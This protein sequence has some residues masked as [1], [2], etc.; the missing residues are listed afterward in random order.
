MIHDQWIFY[1]IIIHDY[2][3]F[4]LILNALNRTRYIDNPAKGIYQNIFSAI[5][6]N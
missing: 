2:D 6:L 3:L 4:A 5:Y 1:D